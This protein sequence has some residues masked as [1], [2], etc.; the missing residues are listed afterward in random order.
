MSGHA[1][2]A[3]NSCPSSSTKVSPFEC[4]FGVN[5]LLPVSLLDLPGPDVPHKEAKELVESLLKIHAQVK[6]NIERANQRYK[7]KADK[8]AQFK[9]Q[10][11][12]GDLVWVHLRKERFP[13]K[14]HNKLM[15]RAAGPYTILK[16]IGDN[17]YIVDLGADSGVH[18]TFNIGDL[19][20]YHGPGELR[21]ILF[22]EGEDET[23]ME[24]QD[25]GQKSE[26]HK[27]EK[28]DLLTL[29]H[30][31]NQEGREGN[32]M[33]HINTSPSIPRSHP[34]PR[35]APP[36]PKNQDTAS[37]APSDTE[38]DSPDQSTDQ[39]TLLNFLSLH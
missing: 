8:G 30:A 21:T 36:D 33:G 24:G 25:S 4:V 6:S 7:S 29:T 22:E 23:I 12:E 26:K 9:K 32:S 38:Q 11:Q 3:Y 1:E 14:R 10:F 5:P 27:Q 37:R 13:N 18:H 31:P 17:A 35:E 2:F 28:N 39:G 15:P 16:K 34:R 19:A 20:P